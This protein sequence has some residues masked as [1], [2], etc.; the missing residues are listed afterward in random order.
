MTWFGW[1]ADD[2]G[3]S[4]Y[5]G[6]VP[7]MGL[8]RTGLVPDV[9]WAI[10]ATGKE[11][12]DAEVLM[13]QR[14]VNEEA[15]P[16]LW[17]LADEGYS[18]VYDLDDLLWGIDPSNKIAHSYY[19]QDWV[20]EYLMRTIDKAALVTVSTPELK[21]EVLALGLGT[22]QVDVL[23]NCV[24]SLPGMTRGPGDWPVTPEGERTRPLRVLWAGS[25]T[26]DADL[27]IVRYATKRMVERG[28]IELWLMGVEYR[29][30]L[31][32][33]SG[34]VPWVENSTYLETLASLGMDVMLAPVKPSRFNHCKSHLKALDAMAAGLIPLTSNGPTY[35]R[36]VRHGENGLM[37][38]WHEHDW[39]QQLRTLANASWDELERLRAGGMETAS[40]YLIDKRA[41]EWFD[42]WGSVRREPQPDEV[43]TVSS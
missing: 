7:L 27:Q 19:A 31:P 26:H 18:Y 12:I 20:Q 36:L 40:E 34:T 21:D 29:D 42:S 11:L 13:A 9:R 24:P 4:W 33:A 39:Y 8:Q 3:C 15:N 32:W 5:R 28:E 25:R 1:V 22:G 38:K 30:I 16:L 35:N 14:T 17:R 43:A 6:A 23:P 2:A 37:A 41:Q 10:S